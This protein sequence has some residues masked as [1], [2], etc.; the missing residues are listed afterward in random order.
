VIAAAPIKV[1]ELRAKCTAA[2]IE[3]SHQLI[4][5]KI[6]ALKVKG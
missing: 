1:Y 4:T 3:E 6:E 2:E 5:S